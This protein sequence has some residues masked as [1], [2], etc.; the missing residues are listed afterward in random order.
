[1]TDDNKLSGK[2]P[3]S[4]EQYIRELFSC[5]DCPPLPESLSPENMWKKISQG[6]GDGQIT[7][8]ASAMDDFSA[9]TAED[10]SIQVD[11]APQS[12]EK[13]ETKAKVLTLSRKKHR[14]ALACSLLL[15]V[16]VSAAFWKLS[17]AMEKADDLAAPMEEPQNAMPEMA[18][19][20]AEETPYTLDE[21]SVPE[22]SQDEVVKEE[23]E[24]ME[25]LG[26]AETGSKVEAIPAEDSM[27]LEAAEESTEEEMPQEED[28]LP[29]VLPAADQPQEPIDPD[30][31]KAQLQARMLDSLAAA[32]QVQA[33]IQEHEEKESLEEAPETPEEVEIEEINPS[34]GGGEEP[35]ESFLATIKQQKNLQPKTYKMD[36]GKLIHNPTA[37]TVEL[38]DVTGEKKSTVNVGTNVKVLA[39]GESFCTILEDSE[40]DSVTMSVY[41]AED[42]SAPVLKESVSHQGQLFDCYQT[43]ADSYT[44]V[45]SIWFDR[46]Q[47]EA[48]D[49]LPKVD[50][51]EISPEKVNIIEGYGETER[52]NYL[53]TSIVKNSSRKTRADLYL[54]P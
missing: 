48:G 47:I 16:G 50:G 44:L 12:Q 46:Q 33:D 26:A 38:Y 20:K 40:K 24:E 54:M 3:L 18:E 34:T 25:P 2:K 39:G 29:P 28:E 10:N 7:V 27:I 15:V 5:A 4:D 11:F 41:H 43:G 32:A 51:V 42:L 13:K 22:T 37:G 49:C 23:P 1:M 45:T 35:K 31:P 30:S 8:P 36:N 52:V 9:Q 6:Q 19:G 17:P 14:V 21:K 53:L